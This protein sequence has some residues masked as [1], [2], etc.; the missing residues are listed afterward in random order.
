ML[1]LDAVLACLPE[2]LRG[3]FADPDVSEIMINGPGR[4]WVER[5]GRLSELPA[6]GLDERRIEAAALA[7]ARPLEHDVSGK[8]PLVDARLRDGSRVAIVRPPAAPY[9]AIT[10]RRF[11]GRVFTPGELV[12][13]GALP[14]AVLAEVAEALAGQRNVLLSGGTGAGKTTLL[15]AFASWIGDDERVVVVE[16]TLELALEAPN[17]LRLEARALEGGVSIRDLIRHA[18]RHR[19]DRLIVGEVRGSEALD[20]LQALNTGHGGSMT[21]LHA[22]SAPA[23]LTRLAACAMQARDADIPWDVL[24]GMI[25]D[26]VNLVVHV[27]RR[28]DGR[29]GVRELVRVQRYDRVLGEWACKSLWPL[30][31]AAEG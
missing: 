14:P 18:L 24:G 27:E 6:P 13:Q 21:T 10:V 4:A 20:L 29:R 16:D 30:E 12:E 7:I 25:A 31:P 17:C 15:Q 2:E 1:S 26:A 5:A 11:G 8:R 9:W 22:N 19:P 3:P 28:G 23:A